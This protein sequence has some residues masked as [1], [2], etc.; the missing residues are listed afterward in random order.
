[1]PRHPYILFDLDGP[2][3]AAELHAG[4][5][6]AAQPETVAQRLGA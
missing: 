6:A 5:R 3:T 1:M 4:R 2:L